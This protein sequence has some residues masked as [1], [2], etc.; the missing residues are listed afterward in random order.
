MN[1]LPAVTA[2]VFA[3]IAATLLFVCLRLRA[4]LRAMAVE[5]LAAATTH[6]ACQ[7]LPRL[8]PLLV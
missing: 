3:L 1:S 5:D 2:L 8:A 4:A 7:A 6:N